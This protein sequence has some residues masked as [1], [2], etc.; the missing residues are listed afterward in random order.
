MPKINPDL[1]QV[2]PIAAG[3]YRARI[4]SCEYK[5]SGK[6]NPMIVPRFA[7]SVD[8]TD[9]ERDSYLVISGAGARGFM[10]LLRATGFGQ[11]ADAYSS[12]D[13]GPKPDFDT[14]DLIGQELMVVVE[15]DVYNDQPTDKITQYLKV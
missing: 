15:G 12:K 1:S 13:G 9:R 6:G 2:G 14:D 8:G 5:V 7:V 10:Q 3:T 4:V 11:L